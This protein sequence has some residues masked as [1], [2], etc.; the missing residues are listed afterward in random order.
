MVVFLRTIIFKKKGNYFEIKPNAKP[1]TVTVPSG[2]T[3]LC[4]TCYKPSIETDD[5]VY[6]SIPIGKDVE[7]LDNNVKS[8]MSR[9]DFNNNQWKDKKILWLGTSIPWG[10]SDED[11]PG[12]THRV[13]HPYPQQVCDALGATLI[14]CTHG[15]LAQEAYYDET[16][17]IWSPKPYGGG[18]TSSGGSTSATIQE[19]IDG[20][21]EGIVSVDVKAY[22]YENT[23]LGK[24]A[25]LYIFDTEPNNT[26]GS[27]TD[28]E[29]FDWYNWKYNDDSS[30]ASHRN[31]YCGALIFEID[32]I[33]TEK[34]D[35]VI[36]FVGE[37]M[38]FTS[39]HHSLENYTI[40]NAGMSLCQKFRIHYIDLT[41][42]LM[43]L[44]KYKTTWVNS[45]KVH[46]KQATYDRMAKMLI[47]ELL[48]IA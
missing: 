37:Y 35:A 18:S 26:N 33:L 15:G 44:G 9:F 48:L 1:Y 14:D 31:T 8:L 5:G 41:E 28:L 46:P 32:Q 11:N 40:R 13:D 19:C 10:Q 22:S 39:T 45:D 38:P 4:I 17:Q 2:A 43:Y 30:F 12:T 24:N 47:N 21:N 6:S 42:K 16:N 29:N 25:D 23:L 7:R 34:P 27:L 36:V 3:Q 20:L